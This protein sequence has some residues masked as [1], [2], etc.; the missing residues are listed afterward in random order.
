[1]RASHYFL[2]GLGILYIVDP[3]VFRRFRLSQN[4]LL[5]RKL[6]P[7]TYNVMMRV[8]GVAVILWG[9]SPLWRHPMHP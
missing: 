9:L 6:A 7:T 5:E 1:M 2:I 8:L 4:G 3:N